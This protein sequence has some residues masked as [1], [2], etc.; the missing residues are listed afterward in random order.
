MTELITN[1]IK[2][3]PLQALLAFCRLITVNYH[4]TPKIAM[5]SSL[6]RKKELV[7]IDKTRAQNTKKL[8]EI[9]GDNSGP[10]IASYTQREINGQKRYE[11]LGL[12]F[13]PK[14]KPKVGYIS[15]IFD[16][17]KNPKQRRGTIGKIV[18]LA[19]KG[20]DV[21]K[22]HYEFKPNKPL[23]L[24]AS[25]KDLTLKGV[26]KMPDLRGMS[27]RSALEIITQMGLTPTISG[28]GKVKK[29]IPRAGQDISTTKKC[30]L[31]C[32]S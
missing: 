18:S 13:W 29:Q 27:L 20:S 14:D 10:S 16:A 24:Y 19:K 6:T 8:L 25:K 17:R 21:L 23:T 22:F 5:N 32:E 30:V 26:N 3:T 7:E 15:V 1:P 2:S 9:I 11:V 31:I 28:T 4:L 12:G